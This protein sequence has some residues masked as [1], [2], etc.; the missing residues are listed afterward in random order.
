MVF[1]WLRSIFSHHGITVNSRVT[2]RENKPKIKN[3]EFIVKW[4]NDFIG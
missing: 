1:D 3:T 2:P 4:R